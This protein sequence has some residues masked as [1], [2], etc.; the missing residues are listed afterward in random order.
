MTRFEVVDEKQ[1]ILSYYSHSCNYILNSERMVVT[2]LTNNMCNFYCE[3]HV[4]FRPVLHGV[5]N[6]YRLVVDSNWMGIVTLIVEDESCKSRTAST[7][8]N[9]KLTWQHSLDEEPGAMYMI[10]HHGALFLQKMP[11]RLA[12]NKY[13]Q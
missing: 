12:F 8:L 11:P 1:S 9:W 2:V 3:R 6:M 13:N 5:N 10:K 4:H 7:C